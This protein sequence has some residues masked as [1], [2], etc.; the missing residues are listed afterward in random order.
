MSNLFATAQGNNLA[1]QQLQGQPSIALSPAFNQVT[2]KFKTHIPYSLT[3]APPKIGLNPVKREKTHLF[4]LGNR[5]YTLSATGGERILFRFPSAGMLV[6]SSVELRFNLAGAADST[7][8]DR[9]ETPGAH[10]VIRSIRVMVG[11]NQVEYIQEYPILAK[12]YLFKRD[13]NDERWSEGMVSFDEAKTTTAGEG[14]YRRPFAN[15]EG[16]INA[17][18]A[19]PFILSGLFNPDLDDMNC[20]PLHL[21]GDVTVE[22]ELNS[23]ADAFVGVTD[24]S[25]GPIAARGAGTIILSNIRLGVENIVLPDSFYSKLHQDLASG[26]LLQIQ[27]PTFQVHTETLG[28]GVTSKTMALPGANLSRVNSLSQTIV[29]ANSNTLSRVSTK[30]KGLTEYQVR[31]GVVD[32]P[33]GGPIANKTDLY[34]EFLRA[35]DLIRYRKHDVKRTP[36]LRDDDPTDALDRH[37]VAC[38]DLRTYDAGMNVMT[39][40][41]LTGDLAVKFTITA[42]DAGDRVVSWIQLDRVLSL[43]G[44]GAVVVE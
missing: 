6:R 36:Y 25:A 34:R 5:S 23:L 7:P 44:Q 26:H 31:V 4:P 1:V 29:P 35:N 21:C 30:I 43:S 28:A 19:V 11:G 32:F 38:T 3:Y 40:R 17:N 24:E 39:G 15:Q 10:S 2:S 37:C 18:Y 20:L 12:D 22:I 41:Q 8:F 33:Q 16:S 14:I 27:I 42:S 9:F 13:N